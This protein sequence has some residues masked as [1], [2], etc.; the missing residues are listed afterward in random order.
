MYG[1]PELAS[2][3]DMIG[4]GRLTP[5]WNIGGVSSR[6]VSSRDAVPDARVKEGFDIDD[7]NQEEYS[8]RVGKRLVEPSRSKNNCYREVVLSLIH[9]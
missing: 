4:G 7:G 6:G 9:I 5:S 1:A 2:E 8:A 3:C